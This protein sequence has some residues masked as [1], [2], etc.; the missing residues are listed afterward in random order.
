MFLHYVLQQPTESL[1]YKC[2]EAQS[3]DRLEGDWIEEAEKNLV[4]LGITLSMFEIQSYSKIMFRKLVREKASEYS[5]TL[6]MKDKET[7][8]KCKN[9]N[10]SDLKVQDYVLSKC[11]TTQQKK[12]PVST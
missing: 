4:D 12:V 9:I 6:L 7:Q 10:F 3:N 2:Y 11:L 1:L 5:L 8:T